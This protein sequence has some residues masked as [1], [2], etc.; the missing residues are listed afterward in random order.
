MHQ[1]NLRS[2]I[3]Q[4]L[5][6]GF[7]GTMVTEQSPI[8]QA[9]LSDSIGGVILFDY[10]YQ[11]KQYGKNII[12]PQQVQHLNHTLHRYNQQRT[13]LPLLIAVDYEGGHVNRLKSDYGFPETVSAA[14]VGQM[15]LAKAGQIAQSMAE[16][17]KANGFNLNFVPTLDVNVNPD[18]PIIGQLE[19][20]FSADPQQVAAYAQIYVHELQQAGIQCAYKHFPGHGSSTGDSHL[21]FVDVTDT[22]QAYELEP[23]RTLFLKPPV[24]GMVMTAHIV[25]RQLDPAGLPATLSQPILTGLLRQQ[26][27][28]EGVIVSDDLQMKAISDHYSLKDT[29]TLSINAGV[30]MLIVG[31]QLATKPQSATE[32]IDCIEDLVNAGQIEKARIE[33]AY[34]RIVRLK[35][36]M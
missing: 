21:G 24:W 18:N 22:W 33:N 25:N 19:R 31:N 2:K 7:D 16:T 26:L 12:S 8:V 15:S 10:H 9:M 14:E 29:L 13:D 4:M 32:I 11:L 28:F 34:E 3:G 23:Y 30:D 6:M 27:Q 5:I 20:S 17:L 1:P 36:A 35:R